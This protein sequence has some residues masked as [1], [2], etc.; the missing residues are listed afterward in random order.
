MNLTRVLNNALPEIPARVLT[1][2]PPRIPPDIVFKEHIEDGQPI[3]RVF[4]RSQELLYRFSPPT[5]ALIQLFDGAR[6]YEEVAQ[7]YSQNSGME[8]SVESVREHAST[9]EAMGFWYKTAQEKN[10][11]LMQ[12]SADERRKALKAKANKYGDLSEIAFPAVNPDKFVTWLH[13][14]TS[15]IYTWWF[16]LLTLIAFCITA[17]I[18]IT[19]WPQISRDTLEFFNFKD[20]TWAD[21][22][23]FYLLALF[24][25]CWH[26]MAHAHACKHYGGRVPAMGFLLVYLT[27]AFYT[28]TTE[29]YVKGSRH[30]RFI[31]AM[32]G[33]HSELLI[34]A[35]ATPIWWLTAPGTGLHNATYLLLLMTGIAGVLLNWNPLMKLD[36]Y[37]MLTEALGISDLK[38]D[39]TAYVSAW[40]KRHVWR[41]PVEVPYVPKRRR[42][43]FVIYA[44]ASGL[45]S[46]TVLYVV[47]RFVGNIFRNFNPEWS[48]VPELGTAYLI[49]RSRLRSFWNF[50][51]FVYLD[52]K[53][54]ILARIGHWK[55]KVIVGAAVIFMALPLWHETTSAKFVLEPLKL[56]LVR[57]RVAGR[58][59]DVFVGEG[60]KVT[61]GAPLLQV[62][63]N[64]LRAQV[65]ASEADFTLAKMKA[66]AATL[67][68]E[69]LGQSIADVKRLRTESQELERQERSLDIISPAEGVV[70]TPRLGDLVGSFV[71]EGTNLIEIADL[72]SMRARVYVSEHDM[73]RFQA[74]GVGKLQFDGRMKIWLA[75]VGNIAPFSSGMASQLEEK[76]KYTGLDP[77]NFYVVSLQLDNSDGSLKPGMV[78]TAKLYGKRRSVAGLLYQELREFF[79]RKVW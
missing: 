5:W 23:V 62:E 31:I 38:E 29:G 32:A 20:K 61:K 50:A 74:G 65:A 19:Y 8:F 9:L 69:G 73:A 41:L 10:V 66:N 22:G 18:S 3:V 47:A 51:K 4:V 2:R 17:T 15:F 44:L 59:A 42:V 56:E 64:A 39:S 71:A 30:Q 12:M 33:A 21:F 7:L 52:K 16:T 75:R 77:L 54:R 37:F 25:L 70:L 76:S 13:D 79:G 68:Y 36:G 49:F 27:P 67:H 63:S 57:A 53:D 60:T 58:I 24:T 46:Y 14:R 11:L 55:T 48:F 43:G 6:S 78:G 45:Y 40:V 1:D 72:S 26:E 28:D 35:V 34:C